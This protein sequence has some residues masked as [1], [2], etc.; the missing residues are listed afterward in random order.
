MLDPAEAAA[1]AAQFGV[2]DEQVRRDHL[3]SHLLAALSRRLPD[4]V[5]FF[6]GTALAR[7]HLPNGRLSEDLDLL[8][9]PE[10]T[11]VVAAV[12]QAMSA[13]VQREYGRLTWNPTLGSVRGSAPAVLRTGDGLQVQVQLIDPAGYPRWPTETRAL[14][15][16]YTDA[17][18]ATLTVPTLAG[19]A[20]AKTAAWHDRRAPRDLYDLWGLAQLGALNADAAEVFARL[21]PTGRP[22]APWMFDEAPRIRDWQTQL[23]GQTRVAVGPTEALTTVGTAWAQARAAMSMS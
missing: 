18:P 16:R 17:P 23:G 6:G 12:E 22:P 5:L 10:R 7:T 14:H 3:I 2:S 9:V 15:Q 20:A 19:F 21:G 8:A 13:G 1:V 11:A 4:Q